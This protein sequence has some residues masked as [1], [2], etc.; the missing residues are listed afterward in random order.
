MEA[1]RLAPHLAGQVEGWPG[2]AVAGQLQGVGSHPGLERAQDLGSRSEEAVS[3][4]QPIDA[5]VG[6]LEVV[7]VNEQADPLA[8]VPQVHEHGSLDALAPESAPEAFDLAQGLRVSGRGHHLPHPRFSSSRVKALLP[9]QVTYWLPLSVS[10][11]S[12]AP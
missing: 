8:G 3:R 11:S 6:A 10:T 9:R 12:G 1:E 2:Q 7:V 5:L 4:H